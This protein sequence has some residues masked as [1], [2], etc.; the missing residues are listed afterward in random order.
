MNSV[1]TRHMPPS[2]SDRTFE[3]MQSQEFKNRGQHASRRRNT[4][5]LTGRKAE[6]L[7]PHVVSRGGVG[8]AFESDEKQRPQ[9]M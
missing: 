1:A 5:Q 4:L 6:L 9:T 3:D 2:S 8:R 7:C